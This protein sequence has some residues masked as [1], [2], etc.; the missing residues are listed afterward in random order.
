[1]SEQLVITIRDVD[2]TDASDA[3]WFLFDNR[4]LLRQGRCTLRELANDVDG[5]IE[6]YATTVIA[7]AEASLLLSVPIPTKQMRKVKQ[8]LPFMVE[9][10]ITEDIE[11]VHIAT[12]KVIDLNADSL[13]TCV[14]AHQLLIHW[15]DVLAGCSIKPKGII[16]E[17]LT[18][19]L[20]GELLALLVSNDRVVIR[21][22][23]YQGF[24]CSVKDIDYVLTILAGTLDQQELGLG[25]V[26]ISYTR[27]ESRAA[28]LADNVANYLRQRYPQLDIKTQQYH[29]PPAEIMAAQAVADSNPAINLLQGGYASEREAGNTAGWAKR[30]ATYAIVG[31]AC[32]VL[33]AVA[34]GQWF[35]YRAD[36]AYQQSIALYKELF[37][38]ER[39]VISPKKQMQNHLRLS[40]ADNNASSF[41]PL[42][43][44][45]SENWG[46]D[47]QQPTLNQMRYN[48]D[49]NALQ[50][51][52]EA[53]SLIEL[54]Q[55]KQRLANNG[56]GIDISSA[57]EQDDIVVG[58][59][60]VRAL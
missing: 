59:L 46:Q 39:R 58:R 54:E 12:P 60:V 5:A 53:R 35:S 49:N 22:G 6:Q 27:G 19:P 20:R 26:A 30:I 3:S 18:V 45:M 42:L 34:I 37:P 1:M 51:E 56:V 38:N 17:P 4:Q 47:D 13:P 43:A 52:V 40:R 29:E 41:L 9:E 25:I 23:D 33:S 48:R 55:L 10:H 24:S 14:I 21:T 44:K 2:I 15:L 28:T 16:A 8:A 36:Q 50:L 7:P 31:V 11:N 57:K 32:Y